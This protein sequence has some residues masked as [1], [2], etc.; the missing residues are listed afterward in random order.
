MAEIHVELNRR[1]HAILQAVASGRGTLLSGSEPDLAIDG[2]WCDHVAVHRLKELGLIAGER[3]VPCGNL[4][5]AVVTPA[6]VTV[7]AE[8]SGLAA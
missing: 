3:P 8:E 4:T 2:G 7:L 5:R 6:G 1:E